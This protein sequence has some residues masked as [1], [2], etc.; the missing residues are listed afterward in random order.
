MSFAPMGNIHSPGHW[1]ICYERIF[2]RH[3][4]LRQEVR[5]LMTE[6]VDAELDIKWYK[7]FE[8]L[9]KDNS[10]IGKASADN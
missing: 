6:M 1:E 9:L 4:N 8:K 10:L 7:K 3:T 2:K 5:K